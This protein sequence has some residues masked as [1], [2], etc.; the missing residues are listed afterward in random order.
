MK[1]RKD[2]AGNVVQGFC[3]RRIE[4]IT[5][6]V[7][8]TPEEHDVAW[9]SP[10]DTTYQLGG[11]G[12]VGTLDAFIPVVIAEGMTYMFTTTMNIEVM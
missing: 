10:V 7:L 8:W 3:T 11:T 12:N 4:A 5:S 1:M 6:G 9:R 2:S